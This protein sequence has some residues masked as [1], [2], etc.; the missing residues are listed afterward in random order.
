MSRSQALFSLVSIGVAVLLQAVFFLRLATTVDLAQWWVVLAFVGGM[1]AADLLSGLIH[2]A[3]DTWGR[4]DF[5]VL[6]PRLLRPFRLHH[7]DPDD[8]LRRPFVDA[9]GDVAFVTIPVLLALLALPLER[10]WAAVVAVFGFGLAGVG[11]WT[12]QIHQWAHMPAP[13]WPI[14]LLQRARV[15]LGHEDHRAHHVGRFDGHYCITTG[16]WNRPLES[17]GFFRRLEHLIANLTGAVPRADER[18]LL[19]VDFTAETDA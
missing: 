16:W 8:F 14:G 5:P 17:I 19:R 4:E 7:T 15:F 9:N 10:D 11:M 3:A 6:G 2:W 12:N 18:H 13:P 1:A